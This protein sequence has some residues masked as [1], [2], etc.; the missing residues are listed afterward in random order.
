MIAKDNLERHAHTLSGDA[1]ADL[2]LQAGGATRTPGKCN[3]YVTYPVAH[4]VT[5]GYAM[6]HPGM[7]RQTSLSEEDVGALLALNNFAVSFRGRHRARTAPENLD[8]PPRAFGGC[9]RSAGPTAEGAAL[10]SCINC[11]EIQCMFK[12]AS[13]LATHFFVVVCPQPREAEDD[14][15][16]APYE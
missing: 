8:D 9:R 11:S 2:R 14:T 16:C 13:P 7:R 4:A 12:S 1:G 6:A 3:V 15:C 10:S 5:R